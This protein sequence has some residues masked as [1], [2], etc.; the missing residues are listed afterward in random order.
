MGGKGYLK[1]MAIALVAG[2]L[3]NPQLA[4]FGVN[5]N[6]FKDDIGY[7]IAGIGRKQE[8]MITKRERTGGSV[9][10]NTCKAEL[11]HEIQ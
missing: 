8:V 1:K 11:P 6:R 3:F 9:S 5:F 4:L 7:Q 10:K 2:Y